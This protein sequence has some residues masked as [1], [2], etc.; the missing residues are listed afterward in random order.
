MNN[1]QHEN[2]SG[3]NFFWRIINIVW[4]NGSSQFELFGGARKLLQLLGLGVL[5]FTLY[6]REYGKNAEE[7]AR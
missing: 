1:G 4:K 3:P 5:D 2:L 7:V 6:S